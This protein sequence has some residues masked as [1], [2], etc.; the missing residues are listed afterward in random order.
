MIFGSAQKSLDQTN[1]EKLEAS[2]KLLQEKLKASTMACHYMASL[3]EEHGV[4]NL[5]YIQRMKRIL[6]GEETFGDDSGSN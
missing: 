5:G 6:K 4:S 1:I 2:A 3:L